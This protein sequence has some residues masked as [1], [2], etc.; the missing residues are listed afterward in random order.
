LV[1]QIWHSKT[2]GA[3]IFFLTGSIHPPYGAGITEQEEEEE[4]EEDMHRQ[5]SLLSTIPFLIKSK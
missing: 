5:Q 1:N 4:E 2:A 3:D